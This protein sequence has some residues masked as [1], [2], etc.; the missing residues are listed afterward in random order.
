[1][2]FEPIKWIYTP[3]PTITPAAQP[4]SVPSVSSL[5]S[6]AAPASSRAAQLIS[7]LSDLSATA[8]YLEAIILARTAG[9]GVTFDMQNEPEL[10]LALNRIYGTLPAGISIAMYG[11]MLDTLA[12]TQRALV[13]IDRMKSSKQPDPIQT[14]DLLTA[15]G[16][17][18]DALCEDGSFEHQLPSLLK[19]LKGDRLLFDNLSDSLHQYPVMTPAPGAGSGY[20][21]AL[22]N[23]GSGTAQT[24]AASVTTQPIDVDPDTAT[25]LNERLDVYENYYNATNDM[26]T[27]INSVMTD[28]NSIAQAYI[29]RPLQELAMVL[30][31]LIALKAFFSKPSLKKLKGIMEALIL[32]RLIA[33]VS[34]FNFLLDRAVQK[35]VSPAMNLINSLGLA[36]AEVSQTSSQIAYLVNEDVQLTGKLTGQITGPTKPVLTNQQKQILNTL[37]VGLAKL[38]GCLSW[39]MSELTQKKAYVEMSAMRILDRKLDGAGDQLEIMQSLS[40]IDSLVAITQSFLNI[41]SQNGAPYGSPPPAVQQAVSQSLNS[42]GATQPQ[43]PTPVTQYNLPEPPPQAKAIF[44]KAQLRS[45]PHVS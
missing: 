26:V 18:E 41:K 9:T 4:V 37:P 24:S 34:A 12:G 7:R 32:P 30:S 31:T 29:A 45:A 28:I 39:G 33:Q 15:T 8:K 25:N 19:T 42:S 20:S 14:A 5:S 1:M 16:K 40:S 6:A 43:I 2:S 10:V 3:P 35:A 22:N 21:P 17:V 38:G 27:S 23:T 13:V 44:A 36:M 11:H